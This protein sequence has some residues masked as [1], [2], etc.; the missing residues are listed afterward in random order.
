MSD[1]LRDQLL[2]MGLAK[3]TTKPISGKSKPGQSSARRSAG[4][5]TRFKSPGAPA[6]SSDEIDLAK[7]WAM[8]EHQE[9]TQR[10]AA[11]RKAAE[12]VRKRRE[13]R[14]RLQRLIDGRVHNKPAEQTELQRHFE[15]G[16][17]IRRVHV[18]TDQLQALNSGALGVVQ[19][20]GRY[21]LLDRSLVEQAR[22][23]APHLV[24][25]LVDPDEA[26]DKQDEGEQQA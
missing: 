9:R 26:S 19:L 7:A 18:D 1:S 13:I 4:K 5:T 14:D 8:R 15:Y 23:F 20:S 10:A 3:A 6:V 24:A 16:G 25:L 12:Q 11:K 17:K 21:L 22:S 2:K